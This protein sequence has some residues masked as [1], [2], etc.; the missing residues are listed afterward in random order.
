LGWDGGGERQNQIPHRRSPNAGDRGC[1]CD[2]RGK[3][4]RG[5]LCPYVRKKQTVRG[6]LSFG[7]RGSGDRLR[8]RLDGKDAEGFFPPSPRLRRAGFRTTDADPRK[9]SRLFAQSDRGSP[10]RAPAAQD[11]RRSQGK[12]QEGECCREEH[13]R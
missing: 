10:V 9:K 6:R 11:H 3:A 7:G 1:R 13:G 8:A 4:G 12:T 5:K 2:R